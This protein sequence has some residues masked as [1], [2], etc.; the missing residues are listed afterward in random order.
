MLEDGSNFLRWREYSFLD[1]RNT[2]MQLR[3]S[4]ESIFFLTPDQTSPTLYATGTATHSVNERGLR[5]VASA[6]KD[7]RVLRLQNLHPGGF[8]GFESDGDN[9]KFNDWFVRMMN[10]LKWCCSTQISWLK[11]QGLDALFYKIP[12]ALDRSQQ[13]ATWEVFLHPL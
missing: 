10:D 13:A 12:I 9:Y 8:T 3:W 5:S 1:N 11:Q 7:V 4:T 2:P 6:L